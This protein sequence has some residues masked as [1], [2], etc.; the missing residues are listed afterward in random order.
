M[1]LFVRETGPA[2]APAIVFLHGGEYTGQSWQPVVER[3]QRYRCLVPD[4]PQHGKSRGLGPFRIG[5]T[6]AAVAELIRARASSGRAHVVGLSLGAQV[7]A[8]LLAT[9]PELVDR[10]VLCGIVINAIPGARLSAF[11]LGRVARVSRFVTIRMK[12]PRYAKISSATIQDRRED[13]NPMD[14]AEIAQIVEE[15]A[16]FTLPPGLDKSDSPTLFLTG[17]YEM[18]FVRR[19]AAALAR[20]MPNG[21]DMIATGML[22][23]WP[24][25]CPDLFSR[26]VDGWLS[27]T[28]LPPEIESP[29]AARDGK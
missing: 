6:A 9:E 17:T 3:M 5:E 13:R 21:I 11:L 22:H 19:S 14:S 26:T 18:P 29:F 25:R 2:G 1:D 4:L 20:R 7:G 16:G 15:S 23:D 12:A 24:L 28:A 8:Q 10:A 27:G